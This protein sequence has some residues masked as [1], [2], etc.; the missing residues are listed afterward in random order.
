MRCKWFKRS[1][2]RLGIGVLIASLCLL[3]GFVAA[4]LLWNRN[5][6]T[7][8]GGSA[9]DSVGSAED[10]SI[11]GTVQLLEETSGAEE[12]S[13]RVGAS[14]SGTD[15]SA[16]SQS[17][18]DKITQEWETYNNMTTEQRLLSS[19]LWGLVSI[20]TDTWTECE[21]EIGVSVYNPLEELDWLEKV[22]HYGMASAVNDMS[23]KHVQ[24]TVNATQMTE[25]KITDIHISAGYNYNNVRVTLTATLL[26][27]GGDHTTGSVCS[28]YATYEQNIVTTKAGVQVL[29][30]TTDESNNTGYYSGDY[31]DPTAYWVRDSVFYILRVFGDET[32]KD[33]IQA[34][35]ERLLGEI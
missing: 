7:S 17:L 14:L 9:T 1:N 33:E 12:S 28:G 22:G 16:I 29:V 4:V 31:Y 6:N 5:Q 21:E 11:Y 10:T 19:K 2:P 24:A 26:A 3:V 15:F 25:G 35:L 18:A 8:G 34:I 20:Q 27:D 30:V 23:V 13:Y 32:D